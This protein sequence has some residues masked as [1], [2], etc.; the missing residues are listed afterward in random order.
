MTFAAR[1]MRF[2]ARI[3]DWSVA[4]RL[5]MAPVAEKKLAPIYAHNDLG[6]V[7]RVL[8]VGCGPGTNT[9]HFAHTDYLGI[10]YHPGYVAYARRRYRRNFIVADITTYTVPAAE[11][12]DFVLLNSLLHHVDTPAGHRIL[13]HLSTCLTE[14]GHVHILDLV[15]P[16]HRSV[17]RWLARCDRGEFPRPVDVWHRMFTT[18]F[19]AVVF[20][21]YVITGLGVPL[22]HMI[23]FKG[24]PRR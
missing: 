5:W 11:R 10:D 12:F 13:S 17:A 7:R 15:L 6:A 20:E 2:A 3:M 8:D 1:P 24:R 22:W 14:D 23:Y 4:Y 19:E 21:P 18:S 9:R 16:E